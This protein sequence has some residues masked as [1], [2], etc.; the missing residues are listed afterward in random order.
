MS[1]MLI[2]LIG[3]VVA[4]A[5]AES[6][7]GAD[8]LASI[9]NALG[10]P[11]IGGEWNAEGVSKPDSRGFVRFKRIQD[12]VQQLINAGHEDVAKACFPSG[13]FYSCHAALVQL[14]PGSDLWKECQTNMSWAGMTMMDVAN[15][16]H[17]FVYQ[18]IQDVWGDHLVQKKRADNQ[19]V[20]EAYDD[21]AALPFTLQTVV[22]QE[23]Y[24]IQRARQLLD[25]QKTPTDPSIDFSPA[26]P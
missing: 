24:L 14:T 15:A 5:A 16:G 7:S 11:D 20:F 26:K 9:Q 1:P 12:F 4:L 3:Q 19:Y 8:L 10:T 2:N 6:I 13:G 21:A 17:C 18:H 22:A 23:T 25:D